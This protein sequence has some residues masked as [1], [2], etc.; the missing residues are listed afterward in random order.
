M[1]W[2]YRIIHFETDIDDYYELHEVFY[3]KNENIKLVSTQSNVGGY[4]KEDL[5][6]SLETML[7]D[8]KERPILENEDMD[9][10]VRLW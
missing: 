2:N 3:D 6:K 5:I 4:S 7:K 10:K 9:K 8:A 1:H